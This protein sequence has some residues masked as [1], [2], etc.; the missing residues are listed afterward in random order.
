ME[1]GHFNVQ[2]SVCLQLKDMD[3]EVE[4]FFFFCFSLFG[5]TVAPA[6]I[7]LGMSFVCEI[8]EKRDP[9]F[10]TLVIVVF[11]RALSQ[12]KVNPRLSPVSASAL[13]CTAILNG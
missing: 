10:S 8:P 12:E 1:G 9:V 2:Q 5:F 6:V 13:S 4:V 7:F 11:L 3:H